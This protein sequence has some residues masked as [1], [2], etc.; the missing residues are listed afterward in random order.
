MQENKTD[1]EVIVTYKGFN[2]DW[3]CRGFQYALGESY[4]HKGEVEACAGGFHACEDP[5][6]VLR[7]YPASKSRFAVVEQSGDLSRHEEDSKVA[8]RKI[9]VKAEIDIVGLIKAGIEWRTKRCT[10]V[11]DKN[12]HLDNT[13]V[14]A[15]GRNESASSSGNYGAATASGNYG[16]ATA[17]GDSGAAT[18]SGYSGAATASGDSGAATASGYSGAATASG[19]SGAATASGNYGA[20]TASGDYGAATASGD[21]GAATASGNYG[22]ATASGDYGA[23]TASGDSGAATASGDSGAATASGDSGAATASGYS[24]AAM[25]SGRNGKAQGKEGCALFL[26][27]RDSDWKIVHAKAAIVGQDGI[28]ADV[29]YKLNAD[30]EFVEVE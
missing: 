28:K 5:L 1:A 15:K 13:A 23:A 9:T 2:A 29:F 7:Y 21:S 18:A 20:A 16:A 22:A 12:S 30:G 27:Y 3:T 14:T 8:S 10:S 25:S 24:G 11:E 19:Y 4:E 6:H 26:V 17:S